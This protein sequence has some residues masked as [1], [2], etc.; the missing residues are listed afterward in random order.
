MCLSSTRIAAE[1]AS[2]L[3]HRVRR[4]IGGTDYD[5]G[6]WPWLVSLQGKIP[7]KTLFGVPLAYQRYY[8]GASLLN[9]R[10]ILTAAHCFVENTL[11]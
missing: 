8:C 1:G 9:D 10:W 2:E 4:V 7:T 6:T 3:H 11:G 5:A